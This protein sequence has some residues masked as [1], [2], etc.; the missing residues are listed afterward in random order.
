[1]NPKWPPKYKY[2]PIWVK[3]GF[4]IDFDVANWYP[5]FGSFIMIHFVVI[6]TVVCGS[7]WGIGK[8][9]NG[10]RCHGIGGFLYFG[11]HFVFKMATIAN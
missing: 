4:Q 7:Y 3:F 11:G 8:N 2:P 1:L 6:S 9:Q 10:C 5:W